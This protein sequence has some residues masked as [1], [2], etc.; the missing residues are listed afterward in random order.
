MKVNRFRRDEKRAER[1]NIRRNRQSI[2]IR[3]PEDS[4]ADET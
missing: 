4:A 1:K 3:I 2:G